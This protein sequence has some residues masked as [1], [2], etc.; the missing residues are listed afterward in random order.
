MGDFGNIKAIQD[1]V[2]FFIGS[3]DGYPVL[4]PSSSVTRTSVSGAG[5]FQGAY[6]WA[7]RPSAATLGAGV[8]IFITD[9]PAGIG[10]RWISDGTRWR[11]VGRITVLSKTTLTSGAIQIADQII[12]QLGPIPAG[13]LAGQIFVLRFEFGRNNNTDAYGT[14]LS[15]RLG[16]AGTVADAT[17][18]VINI[19][20]LFPAASGFLSS[21]YENWSRATSATAVARIG[22]AN[23]GASLILAGS[24][25]ALQTPVTVPDMTTS[26][27][28]ISV[29][30]T[31]AT[32]TTT[33]P[34]T[35]Y[36]ALEIIG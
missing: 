28:Y 21:G 25:A 13:M 35:G 31:M 8:S 16:T 20:S 4:V 7:L 30:T 17:M 27:L 18:A 10:S 9:Y 22:A 12:G 33:T 6:T 14:A 5:S 3:D 2:D 26:A 32:A 23:G 11:P 24:G 1:S 34:Q 29:S 36:M 19:S 15:I